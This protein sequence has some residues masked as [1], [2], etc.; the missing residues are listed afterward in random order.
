MARFLEF[1][2][3]DAVLFDCDGVLIDSEPT[4]ERAWR[5]TLGE[6]G[7][8]L[9][10]FGEWVGT[11]DEELAQRFAWEAAVTP[12]ELKAQ[13]ARAL[14]SALETEPMQVFDDAAMAIQRVTRSSLEMAVVTNSEAW[15]LDAILRSADLDGIFEVKVTAD[16][17]ARPKPSPDVYLLAAR[18]LD[19]DPG[20]C[21]VV[22]D[23]PTGV[24][25]ARA[26]GMRVVAVDRGVFGRG[27]LSAATRVVSSLAPSASEWA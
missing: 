7:I 23:S 19:T 4:S 9:G 14:V 15:R 8:E 21:L 25:A 17:V 24:A 26:A 13:A 11:T 10:P 22:E 16:D 5:G 27:D 20:R 2:G 12:A 6:Y 18:L 1:E 3:V